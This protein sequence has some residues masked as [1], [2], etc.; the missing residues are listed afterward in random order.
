MVTCA[1]DIIDVSGRGLEVEVGEK[2]FGGDGST[3]DVIGGGWFVVHNI[4]EL[5][6]GR[7]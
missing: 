1:S 7:S 4:V 5:E 2:I 6:T 3:L